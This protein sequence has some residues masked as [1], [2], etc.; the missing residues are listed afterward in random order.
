MQQT[1]Q[2]VMDYLRYRPIRLFGDGVMCSSKVK[3]NIQTS[4]TQ[5][6]FTRD[7]RVCF[8]TFK[9]QGGGVWMATLDD[10]SKKHYG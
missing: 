6:S 2:T 4:L 7:G 8:V 1:A 10:A 3:R 9:N 5:G